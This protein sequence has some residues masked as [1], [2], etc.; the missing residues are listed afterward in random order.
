MYHN[1]GEMLE[2]MD[3]DRE[4][5][6]NQQN[7]VQY[8]QE[9]GGEQE[10]EVVDEEIGEN[11]VYDEEMEEIKLM[12]ISNIKASGHQSNSKQKPYLTG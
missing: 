7:M 8:G 5:C 1:Q 12:D 9:Y 3:V 10:E 6:G 11:E 4:D 2:T